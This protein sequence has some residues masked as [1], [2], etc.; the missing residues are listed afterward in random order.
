[1]DRPRGKTER[2]D[3]IGMARGEGRSPRIRSVV[4][5]RSRWSL[6]MATFRGKGHD[7][8]TVRPLPWAS[9]DRPVLDPDPV[10]PAVRFVPD[11]PGPSW[12]AAPGLTSDPP[13]EDR[14]HTVPHRTRIGVVIHADRPRRTDPSPYPPAIDVRRRSLRF[15]TDSVQTIDSSGY[16]HRRPVFLNLAFDRRPLRRCGCVADPFDPATTDRSTFRM[17]KDDHR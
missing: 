17:T 1:M 7:G 16:P 8:S 3:P 14:S 10:P 11:R 12:D 2:W 6:F 13:H 9:P 4:P 5:I 15:P